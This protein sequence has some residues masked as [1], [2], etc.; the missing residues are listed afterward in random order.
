MVLYRGK[1]SGSIILSKSDN[2]FLSVW[3]FTGL[4]EKSFY[5]EFIKS[6]T[7]LEI[8]WFPSSELIW[9]LR[10]LKEFKSWEFAE[11]DCVR[12]SFR[13]VMRYYSIAC[14]CL[15]SSTPGALI[16]L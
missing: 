12:N 5:T 2:L 15:R 13:S 4:F 11:M 7:P 1:D 16:I 10:L 9:L 6:D 14:F 8:W 3:G